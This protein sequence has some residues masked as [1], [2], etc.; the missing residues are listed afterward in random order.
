PITMIIEN[1]AE[2]A[3]NS[4][5][6]GVGGNIFLQAD[7]LTL[8]N[9]FINAQT[10]N[11]NG[12]GIKLQI[13]N[14][15]LLANNSQITSTAGT[16]QSG[17]NGGNVQINAPFIIGFSTNP[18]HEIIAN[19]FSGK[20]GNILINTNGI[21]GAEYIDIQASSQSGPQ[22][23][24][25]INTPGINPANGLTQLPSIPIDLSALINN[26]CQV[27]KR[28]SFTV[29]G[30]GGIPSSPND[31]FTADITVADWGNSANITQKLPLISENTLH[32]EKINQLQE[33]KEAQGFIKDEK[34]NIILTSQPLQVKVNGVY[35]HPL[36]CE[37][38]LSNP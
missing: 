28:N 24:V 11:S 16:L 9:G 22:G 2:I 3:V 21:F 20:G 17:G 37:R 1:G 25:E 7:N 33:I 23:I 18:N 32:K 4:E 10:A 30:K 6:N 36:D 29:T 12:G 35:L 27:S 31:I 19:A 13:G 26:S 38:L 14:Y 5:G 15:L 8:N 34:G